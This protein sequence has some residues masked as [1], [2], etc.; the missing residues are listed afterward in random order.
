[1]ALRI[2]RRYLLFHIL[3]REE[4]LAPTLS[5]LLFLLQQTSASDDTHIRILLS[6]IV[7]ADI[8]FVSC[9]VAVD[10]EDFAFC[11]RFFC[12]VIIPYWGLDK[13]RST[14]T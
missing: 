9:A 11:A 8:L 2:L 7:G 3:D 10:P 5:F 13:W 4:L 6:Y 12:Q 14:T 1:M